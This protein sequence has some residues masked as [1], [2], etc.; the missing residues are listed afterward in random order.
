MGRSSVPSPRCEGVIHL[1]DRRR[2]SFAEYGSPT[3][4]PV[5]WHHGT[6]GARRQVPPSARDAALERDVRIIALDRPGVGGSSPHQYDTI[7]GFAD[8]V[9]E[10]ADQLGVDR[11]ATIGLSGGGPYALACAAAMPERVVSGAVLG[12]VAPSV[13]PERAA[14]GIV[15]LAVLTEALTS[16]TQPLVGAGL[17]LGLKSM[18]WA[19]HL[20]FEA[21]CRI[22]P[23]GDE[24]VLRSPGM[25]EFFLDDLFRGARRQFRAVPHD[26]VLFGRDWGF[27]LGAIEVP[28]HFWHGDADHIIPLSHGQHMASLVPGADLRVRPTESHLGALA[29]SEQVLDVI[30]ADWPDEPR[31]C[32][33]DNTGERAPSLT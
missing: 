18:R 11:F 3:G 5:L 25:E 23:E 9:R 32:V 13:G 26:I 21:Y 29:I 19:Q 4:R 1:G 6:P 22:T 17:W 14:G 2:I 27:E 20:A 31:D 15:H 10:C 8:D 16:R 12:G 24:Q 30:L 28:I 33:D 7:V